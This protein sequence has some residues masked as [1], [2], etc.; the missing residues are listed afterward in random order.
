MAVANLLQ[1][2]IGFFRNIALCYYL[3]QADVGLWALASSFLILAAPLAVLG[4][5]GS[6]GRYIETFRST[7][8]LHSFLKQASWC[9]ALGIAALCVALLAFP[10]RTASFI[11][12]QTVSMTAILVVVVTL[13]IVIVFNTLME[14]LNGLR[15][16]SA[17]SMM[18]LVSSIAF[19]TL[20]VPVLMVAATWINVVAC[21]AVAMLLGIVPGVWRLRNRCGS[22][23][24]SRTLLPRSAMLRRVAPFAI[25]V[26]ATDLLTNLFD[27]VDRYM[28]LYFAGSDVVANQ[29]AVGEFHTARIIP[30]LFLSLA[31]MLAGM[32]LPYWSSDWEAGRRAAVIRSLLDSIKLVSLTFWAGSIVV[33]QLVSLLFEAF[34]QGRYAAA[35]QAM[36]LA[37]V[38]CIMAAAAMLVVSFLRCIEANRRAV[39]AAIVGLASNVVLNYTLVTRLGVL[40][41]MAGTLC[42]TMIMLAIGLAV[43]ASVM[44]GQDLK[45]DWSIVVLLALPCTVLISPTISLIAFV[46]VVFMVGRS[47]YLIDQPLR[48]QLDLVVVPMLQRVRMPLATLWPTRKLGESGAGA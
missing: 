26:W 32:I 21:Y 14:L 5:P 4:L 47:D 24:E 23:F 1:R 40:G 16:P 15:Q 45:F 38:H 18:Q 6:F 9:S 46:V 44:R 13:L 2:G 35:E 33:L 11:F 31:T 48:D 20:S 28:L 22:V 19:S 41:A 10:D 36:P 37:M 34:F 39:L 17:V 43:M 42:S 27:V 30:V 7:G 25:A 8:Q 12:G 3:T 29:A